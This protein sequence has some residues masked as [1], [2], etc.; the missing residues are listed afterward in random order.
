[1]TNQKDGQ[2]LIGKAVRFGNSRKFLPLLL[3]Q[4]YE[5]SQ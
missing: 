5:Y 3:F 4:N 1:M 2:K